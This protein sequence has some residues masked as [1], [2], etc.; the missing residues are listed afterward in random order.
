[1]P[2]LFPTLQRSEALRQRLALPVIAFLVIAV[3]YTAARLTWEVL[4]APTGDAMAPP[5]EPATDTAQEGA[6]RSLETIADWSLFGEAAPTEHDE[7]RIEAPETQL[8]LELKGVFYSPDADRASAIISGGRDGV[9]QYQPGDN[10]AGGR[11]EAIYENRVVLRREGS[12]ETLSLSGDRVPLDRSLSEIDIQSSDG[13][14]AGDLASTRTEPGDDADELEQYRQQLAEDP[15]R[16]SQMVGLQPAT[17]EGEMVGVRVTPGEDEQ[18]MEL[19]GLEPDDVVVSIGSTTLDTPASAFE[20]VQGLD[21]DDT[22]E[23]RV[24]RDG[25][26]QTLQLDFN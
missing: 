19:L 10:L 14:S 17:E 11:V 8:A 7:E 12:H 9:R 5:T 23:M 4:P 3:A 25:S 18:I 24:R 2:T 26:E 22:V 1:M 13:G 16:L 15:R 20:A 6:G 21:G